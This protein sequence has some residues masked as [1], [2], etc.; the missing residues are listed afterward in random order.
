[1]DRSKRSKSNAVI[2]PRKKRYCR[3]MRTEKQTLSTGE[4][5]KATSGGQ[6]E[7]P[8][9]RAGF[10]CYLGKL[11]KLS[12]RGGVVERA[13]CRGLAG[14][15]VVVA[16]SCQGSKNTWESG[17]RWGS[18]CDPVGGHKTPTSAL[19][20]NKRREVVS[21]KPESHLPGL[22]RGHATDMNPHGPVTQEK[23][24]GP[25]TMR[26]AEAKKK[27]KTPARKVRASWELYGGKGGR[28]KRRRHTERGG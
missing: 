9:A 24:I 12:R 25:Y 27:G 3:E 5:S 16:S 2:S 28:R 11:V 15:G 4:S 19:D 6:N 14:G 18:K 20:G 17:T 10:E 13:F 1:V 7:A 22:L 8:R 26:Y 21:A 23:T